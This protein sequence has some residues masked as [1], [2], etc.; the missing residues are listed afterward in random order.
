VA[1]DTVAALSEDSVPDWDEADTVPD[2]DEEDS[3]PDWD[4]DLKV[5]PEALPEAEAVS[6]ATAVRA[7]ASAEMYL[8]D[9][10]GRQRTERV[11]PGDRLTLMARRLY[12]HKAFW[13]YIYEVNRDR[14]TSPDN[15][16][17]GMTLRLPDPAYWQID[18]ASEASVQT[19]LRR[20]AKVA[21]T[22]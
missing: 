5:Q 12:G 19:A 6:E 20:A 15:V 9:A 11:E 2:W 14:L 22:H 18:S 7:T 3:V 21:E 16:T 10:D 4:E 1:A 13:V 8:L 17:A